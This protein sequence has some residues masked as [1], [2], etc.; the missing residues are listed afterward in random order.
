MQDT[1]ILDNIIK[2]T[3]KSDF[4]VAEDI[5]DE[6]DKKLLA[7]GYQ[8]TPAIREELFNRILKKPIETSI[9]PS[10]ALTSLNISKAAIELSV[11]TPILTHLSKDIKVEAKDLH[12]LK[13]EPL[14]AL[15]L[16][17]L[18]NNSISN[19]NHALLVTLISRC[20]GREMGLDDIAITELSLAALL[21]D[22]GELYSSAAAESNLTSE[23]WRKIMAQPVIASSVIELHMNY[24]SKVS[25]AVLE[26]HERCDG[27]GYPNRLDASK[28]SKNGQIL[29]VAEAVAGLL[30]SGIETQSTIFAIKVSSRAYPR[31]V[32]NVFTGMLKSTTIP[33]S[34]LD[35]NTSIEKLRCQMKVIN[36]VFVDLTK[37]RAEH[38]LP[39][40]NNTVR[41]IIN[42][43]NVLKQSIYSSG[44]QYYLEETSW[45]HSDDSQIIL[46]ELE[47]TTNEVAWQI[48]D[49]LRDSSFRIFCIDDEVLVK[50]ISICNK[51][52]NS[53]N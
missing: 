9:K 17:V 37:F 38:D 43:L 15:L 47:I 4:H 24:S 22:I 13:V 12:Y 25:K 42:R 16:T 39:D 27:T 46:L 35:K 40:M 45:L 18:R 26:H 6:N 44:I 41:H 5:Y 1:E 33:R 28:C 49:T 53:E 11:N 8:I 34:E 19:F 32:L 30:K 21:H 29:I 36:E 7:K 14:A 3:E 23:S 20:I 50:F 51:L 31:A 52:K 10:D 2:A 48:K